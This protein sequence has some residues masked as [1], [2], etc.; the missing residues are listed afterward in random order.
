MGARTQ[1]EDAFIGYKEGL[2]LADHQELCEDVHR[3]C[4]E[5]QQARERVLN[6]A[7]MR[8]QCPLSCNACLKDRHERDVISGYATPEGTFFGIVPSSCTACNICDA[9]QI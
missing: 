5:W 9:F 2:E 6:P 1:R 8:N 4:E 3:N 7:F